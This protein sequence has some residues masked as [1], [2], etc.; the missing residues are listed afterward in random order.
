MASPSVH[1]EDSEPYA[2]LPP[3]AREQ[4]KRSLL[5]DMHLPNLPL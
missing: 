2:K 4:M 5:K 1:D 3:D